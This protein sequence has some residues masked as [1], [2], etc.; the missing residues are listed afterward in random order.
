[1]NSILTGMNGGYHI[2]STI[3]STVVLIYL[4]NTISLRWGVSDTN[5]V[6]EKTNNIYPDNDLD[7]IQRF[8]VYRSVWL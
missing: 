5:D 8:P 1:M 6:Y 3:V 2:R 7:N 4:Y